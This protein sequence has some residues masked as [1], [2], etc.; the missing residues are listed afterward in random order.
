ML[1]FRK[2]LNEALVRAPGAHAGPGIAHMEHP[3]DVAAFDGADSAKHVLNTLR[4]VAAGKE[5]LTRK[6][7]DSMSFQAIRHP[8]G[9]V[10]VKYKGAGSHYN[11]SEEEVDQQHGHKPYLAEPLKAL[12][13]HLGKVLPNRPGEYQGGVVHSENRPT[14][15]ENGRVSFQPNTIKYSVPE[16][17]EE[18]KKITNSQ[19]G[20]AIHTELHGP[21][22]EPEPIT[23]TSEFRSHPDVHMMSHVVSPQERKIEPADRKIVEDHL[24]KAEKL[25][26]QQTHAH[27]AGH[28]IHLRTYINHTIRTGEAPTVE[29]FKAHLAAAHDKKIAGVKTDAAKASKQAVK[30][31][32]MAHID[33]NREA[34]TRSLQIHH[35][36][37]QATNHLADALSRRAHGGY[38]HEIAGE[39]ADPEGFVA[40]GLKVVNRHNFSRANFARSAELRAPKKD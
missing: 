35:H 40:G 16:H 7:D 3:S 13:R 1:S 39:K 38:D 12:V 5:P 33:A 22:K 34:F 29:G 9:R 6:I 21:N 8:D 14:T 24:D 11:Y 36:I 32:D 17:S 15:T 10:G 31:A 26:G 25:L 18:G 19:V 2:F 20:V 27:T 30:D 23:S 37:Q 4:G 28:E